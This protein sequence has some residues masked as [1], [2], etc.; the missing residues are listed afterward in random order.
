LENYEL[1][2]PVFESGGSKSGTPGIVISVL[3]FILGITALIIS[4]AIPKVVGPWYLYLGIL[5]LI[6]L[7]ARWTYRR[8]RVRIRLFQTRDKTFTLVVHGQAAHEEI[9]FTNQFLYWYNYERLSP[10]AGGGLIVKY[11]LVISSPIGKTVGFKTM[12]GGIGTEY[13]GWNL[14]K[15][16]LSEGHGVYHIDDMKGLATC[17]EKHKT[18]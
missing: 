11:F 13:P 6:F 3:G 16:D 12:L 2:T 1:S 17:L 8:D 10:K 9:Q 15:N 18:H 14:G 4:F 5:C 7:F